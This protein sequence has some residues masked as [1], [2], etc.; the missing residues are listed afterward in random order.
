ME[1][2]RIEGYTVDEMQASYR[3]G[4]ERGRADALW[5]AEQTVT[6]RDYYVAG[7]DAR[8]VLAVV[9]SVA[10]DLRAL[11]KRAC[12]LGF[13]MTDAQQSEMMETKRTAKESAKVTAEHAANLRMIRA[14]HAVDAIRAILWPGG[15]ASHEWDA[16]S[17]D[18]V[19]R[20]LHDLGFGPTGG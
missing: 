8:T 12:G 1:T 13:P 14:E 10:A 15:D 19:A 16:E 7:D 11:A 18:A 9:A 2:K 5:E 6:E 20:V 4:C 17:I 3:D